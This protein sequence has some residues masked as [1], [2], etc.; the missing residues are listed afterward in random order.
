MARIINIRSTA[1]FAP[2][3]ASRPDSTK[4]DV[5]QTRE[6][7]KR[8]RKLEEWV[9]LERTRQA[10]NRYQMALDADFFDGLQW[11]QED[12]S[13]LLSRGQAPLVYNWV[14]PAVKWVT[15]TE[16]RTRIDFKVYPRSDDDRN[17]SENKTK[18]MK[19]LSDINKSAFARSRA[20]EDAAKVGVGWLE[21]GIRGDPTKELIF[22]RY[23]SWR[24]VLHDSFSVD[25]DLG[26]AR[27]VIR[28][29]WVD[30]DIAQAV[31]PHRAAALASAA[32]F[33]DL[34]DH[35]DSDDWYLGQ[36][37]SDRVGHEDQP[38][39]RFTYIDGGA[40]LFNKRERVK[41]YEMW[42]RMPRRMTFLVG[43]PHAGVTFD[44]N[45]DYHAWLVQRQAATTIER[46]AMRMHCGV[47]IK[48]TFLQDV[49]SPYRH[50]DF[51]FTPI[52][53]NRRDR[54]G[55]PYG[56]VRQQRDPQEDFNKRMS[57]AL[58]ALST[59]RV[60]MDKGA[61]DDIE[62]TRE[63][64]ARP[65]SIFVVKPGMRFE[66]DTDSAV[67]KDH[68]AYAEVDARMIQNS[69]G[70]TDELMGRK[71]NAV[72]GKAIEARQDQGSTVTT[73]YFDN[74]RFATQVHGQ[75]MLSLAEQ[76]MTMTKK[77][78]VIGERRGYDFLTINEPG[79]DDNGQPALLNDITKSQA[80][81][82][83][84]AQ[85]FRETMRQAS[86]DALMAFAGDLAK[87][88]PMLV[89]RIMDDILEYA[90]LPGAEA[91]IQTIREI[92]GKQPRDKQ[93]T[94]EEEAQQQQA[95]QAEAA[96][97]QLAEHLALKQ[98][99]MAVQEQAAKVQE[100]QAKAMKTAAEAQVVGM[101]NE[102]K[103]QYDE[104]VAK[105]RQDTAKLVDTL[106]AQV[107]QLR[108]DATIRAAEIEQRAATEIMV[109]RENNE[110]RERIAQIEQ[111]AENER[112]AAE[113]ETLRQTKAV[114]AQT[115]AG[116]NDVQ[117]QFQDLQ[118]MIE[119]T[120]RAADDAAKRAEQAEKAAEEAEKA[121]E[122]AAKEADARVKEVEKAAR[123]TEKSLRDEVRA[124]K[125][126]SKAEKAEAPQPI[127][128]AM[129]GE[130][131]VTKE[132]SIAIE[133]DAKG[134]ITG[135]K[136]ITAKKK[137]GGT[138]PAGKPASKPKKE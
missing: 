130:E 28:Q 116:I 40:A 49:V 61:V 85:D 104:K 8:L 62:E 91:I 41:I 88:D 75:K 59:R 72:S 138:K 21:C 42:Y 13:T 129:P 121:A 25:K 113:Q 110:S 135:F 33:S 90:D 15:G 52:W 96:K 38:I 109:A 22:D 94:P 118:R 92:T 20:F 77:I 35:D 30:L 57:K 99:A 102:I 67:A 36:L 44:P 134:K 27:Y 32:V 112:H 12:A 115:Q 95:K 17:E 50:N 131:G 128:I 63:E 78:R 111:A 4:T 124:S 7:E 87:V 127:V 117:S 66:L 48:G 24:N 108:N 81:F 101:G 53:G 73:D 97:K 80:D 133:T 55:A 76:Y 54:D 122:E 82:I 123:E 39:G 65:D 106:T 45:D 126:E 119:D 132:T 68:M 9:E 1:E 58:H 93:P 70:V 105:L 47:F 10:G 107:T 114:E 26:D 43:G 3:P 16:K 11:S 37:L 137:A 34:G 60:F 31:W 103:A 136:A 2:H 125:E 5:A 23:E 84:S 18:L 98:A 74:L 51:P 64:A 19:Y 86:F 46:V 83:V 29:K 69:G 6:A 120:Q 89:M 79:T 14:Y 71:T 100:L 56:M